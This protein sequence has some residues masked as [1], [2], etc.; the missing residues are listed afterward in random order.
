MTA[1][2]SRKIAPLVNRMAKGEGL[3]G[4]AFA[5]KCRF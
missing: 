5:A 2:A 4:H 3:E 1:E